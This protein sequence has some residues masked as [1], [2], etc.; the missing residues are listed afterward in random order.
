MKGYNTIDMYSQFDWV[1]VNLH[2]LQSPQFESFDFDRLYTGPHEDLILQLTTLVT[3]FFEHNSAA[4]FLRVYQNG[5]HKWSTEH[6]H[7]QGLNNSNDSVG[8]Y[9]VFTLQPV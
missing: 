9:H 6:P 5:K 3:G 4:H 1:R 8:R 7:Q 2:D